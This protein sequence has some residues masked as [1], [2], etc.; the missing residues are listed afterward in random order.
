MSFALKPINPKIQ[1]VLE[2]KSKILSRES[3]A[4]NIQAGGMS[5]KLKQM[6]SIY[7]SSL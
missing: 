4:L 1:R 2:E 6:Q 3:A 7:L 5:D